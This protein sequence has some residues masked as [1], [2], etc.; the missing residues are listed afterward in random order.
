MAARIMRAVRSALLLCASACGGGGAGPGTDDPVMS[1]ASPSGDGQSGPAGSILPQQLRV[2]L[3]QEGAPVAGRTV[4]WELLASGGSVAP[5]SSLTGSDGIAAASVTLPPFAATSTVAAASNG[6][7][8][9]PVRFSVS[10]TGPTGAVTVRVA[11]N[12][13]QPSVFQLTA[14]GTVT[15]V[16][17]SGASLHNVTPVPPNTQPASVNPGPPA[18]HNAPY[19]FVV[20]FPGAG[21]FGFFCGVHGG[22][23]TGMHG[24]LTVVP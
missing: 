5:A 9:S 19:S 15:F 2:V 18:T 24:T 20:T 22:P 17:Q 14:G 7:N 16:W 13:F 3:T 6:V 4:T 11:N 10:S 23:G 21:T 8:G 12:E 1:R